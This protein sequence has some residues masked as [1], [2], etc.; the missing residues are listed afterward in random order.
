[1]GSINISLGEIF[2]TKERDITGIELLFSRD[3]KTSVSLIHSSYYYNFGVYKD[4]NKEYPYLKGD[5]YALSSWNYKNLVKTF[6]KD[7]EVLKGILT[8]FA[9]KALLE[10]CTLHDYPYPW[11]DDTVIYHDTMENYGNMAT[12]ITECIYFNHACLL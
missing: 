12:F 9:K 1:M 10:L 4:R 2:H 7:P 8:V 5:T 11:R 6:E 3:L